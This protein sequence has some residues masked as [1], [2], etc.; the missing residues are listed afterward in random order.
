MLYLAGL[1]RL[2]NLSDNM[3]PF[4]AV[5]ICS[6]VPKQINVGNEVIGLIGCNS[7]AIGNEVIGLIGCN[8]SAIDMNLFC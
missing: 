1:L 8:S 4:G 2:T 7:S 3:E 5:A 6:T